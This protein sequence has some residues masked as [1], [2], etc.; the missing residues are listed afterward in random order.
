M[1]LFTLRAF[2]VFYL[3]LSVSAALGLRERNLLALLNYGFSSYM[4]VIAIT[5]AIF[6]YFHLFDFAR[7][8]GQLIYVGA[9]FLIGIPL[10][11]TIIREG[12]GLRPA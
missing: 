1:S 5:A 11:I 7:H 10:T 3:S 9:Y 8:P 12:T 2:A 4:L 6:V